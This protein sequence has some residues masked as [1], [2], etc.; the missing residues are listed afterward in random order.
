MFAYLIET[1]KSMNKE[2]LI[3]TVVFFIFGLIYYFFKIH[4]Q[5]TRELPDII[6]IS[7]RQ[8][9]Q[10]QNQND[11]R[12]H[13]EQHQ[14]NSNNLEPIEIS[15]QINQERKRFTIEVTD[16]IGIFINTHL[17]PLTNNKNASLLFQGR[18]LNPALQF[19]SYTA[20]KN[21]TVLLC[22]IRNSDIP[23]NNSQNNNY[24]NSSNYLI[25]TSV[26][27]Y[28][29]LTHG[30]ILFLLLILIINYKSY[31]ELFTRSTL[32]IIQFLGI[33]WAF[34]FSKTIATLYYYRKIAY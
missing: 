26:S 14:S 23:E 33:F 8:Q 20:I 24:N 11:Q 12:N 19:S 21:G 16:N 1:Y 7:Q 17:R 32:I 4:N 15:V 18:Q 10:Q 27:F 28:T 2:F 5:A 25:G 13:Q 22:I 3:T 31:K 29:L 34:F 6:R 30:M 9:Q